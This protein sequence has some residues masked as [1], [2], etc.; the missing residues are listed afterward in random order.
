[1]AG[2]GSSSVLAYAID[3]TPGALTSVA[4]SPFA[5]GN[6][7][8]CVAVNPAGT[9]VYVVNNGANNVSAYT[10]DPTTGALTPITGSP[11]AAGTSP[12][13]VAVAQP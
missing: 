8:A 12:Q 1:M 10:V 2:S 11:F 13:S 6:S 5:A 9:F 3:A 4:G 7:P